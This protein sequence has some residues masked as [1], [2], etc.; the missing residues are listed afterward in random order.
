MRP[1]L[2]AQAAEQPTPRAVYRYFR[3]LG[4]SGIDVGL[5]SLADTLATYGSSLPQET[6][7]RL[8]DVVCSLWEAYWEKAEEKISPA[9]LMDGHEVMSRFGLKPGPK[10]GEL[11]EAL[12]EAQAIGQVTSFEEAL[13]FIGQLLDHG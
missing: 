6:W 10:I 3:D 2:L 1:L 4:P 8:L 12:R 5:L 7:S 13:I 11:L 9:P